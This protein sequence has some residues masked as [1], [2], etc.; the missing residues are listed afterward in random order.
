MECAILEALDFNIMEENT[1]YDGF[2]E[3]EDNY[4]YRSKEKIEN[5]V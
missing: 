5:I 2:A 4:A 1:I 3:L